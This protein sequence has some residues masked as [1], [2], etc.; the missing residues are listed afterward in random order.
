MEATPEGRFVEKR[1]GKDRVAPM[2]SRSSSN[3]L[4]TL[5]G[6]TMGTG[7]HPIAPH[8]AHPGERI[9]APPSRALGGPT[10]TLAARVRD[11]PPRGG[12]STHPLGVGALTTGSVHPPRP[13]NSPYAPRRRVSSR[14]RLPGRSAGEP[15]AR[16]DCGLAGEL[17]AAG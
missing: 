17:I 11:L 9:V 2:R 4:Y 7:S 15:G 6:G 16:N 12:E 8:F 5:K 14:H 1:R 10:A 13:V 3:L